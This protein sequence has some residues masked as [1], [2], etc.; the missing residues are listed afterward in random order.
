MLN[1]INRSKQKNSKCN[2]QNGI[3]LIMVAILLPSFILL[4]ALLMD[5]GRM[6][7]IAKQAQNL[8]D[9]SSNAGATLLLKFETTLIWSVDRENFLDIKPTVKEL[10]KLVSIMGAGIPESSDYFT[11]GSIGAI[12]QTNYTH[13]TLTVPA[14]GG[15]SGMSI[16]L[17]RGIR[18]F[19]DTTGVEEYL[20]LDSNPTHWCLANSVTV[21]VNVNGT[22]SSF[23]KVLGIENLN[24]ISRSST[25]HVRP[26][27]NSCGVP[28]CSSYLPYLTNNPIG[29]NATNVPPCMTS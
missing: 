2:K 18:C 14:R 5:T 7:I 27:P 29:I 28:A 24:S 13:D 23:G 3:I 17:R 10:A 25:S 20:D 11:S 9:I 4:L 6:F 16:T 21:T 8:A 15:N 1:L 19:N 12:G 22:W 26:V